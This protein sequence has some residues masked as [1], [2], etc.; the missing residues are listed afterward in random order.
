MGRELFENLSFAQKIQ[1]YL[2]IPMFF[3]LLL[4][5]YDTY[6]ISNKNTNIQLNNLINISSKKVKK[7][8]TSKLITFME[9][10]AKYYQL[11]INSLKIE[12]GISVIELR[13]KHSNIFSFLQKIRLHFQTITFKINKQ[14]NEYSIYLTVENKY[15]FNDE[16]NNKEFLVIAGK[17]TT[18]IKL[19]AIVGKEA[20]I[21]G[22]WYQEG[23]YYQESKIIKINTNSI[24]LQNKDTKQISLW[25]LY[26]ESL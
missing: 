16:L 19:E 11:K 24:K 18:N 4:F 26:N 13:G 3:W 6:I 14:E 23:A 12:T 21:D 8:L 17:N 5:S 10:K 22:T 20:L 25:E 9:E 1:L 2:L 15:L 7:L